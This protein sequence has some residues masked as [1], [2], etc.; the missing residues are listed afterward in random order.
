GLIIGL[1]ERFQRSARGIGADKNVNRIRFHSV[2]LRAVLRKDEAF[3]REIAIISGEGRRAGVGG[4]AQL[5]TTGAVVADGLHR[6]ARPITGAIG[7]LLAPVGV[8]G[9]VIDRKDA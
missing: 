8:D 2:I 9:V 5:F 4:D 6:R 3:V 7:I 1:V